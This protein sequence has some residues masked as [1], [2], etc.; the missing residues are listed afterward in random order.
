[1]VPEE[2]TGA[3]LASD[4]LEKN[5]AADTQWYDD[6]IPARGYRLRLQ[7][8]KAVYR[9]FQKLTDAEGTRILND[10]PKNEG[11]TDEELAARKNSIK[12]N[13]FRVTVS[14]IGS[15]GESTYGEFESIF[16]SDS[17]PNQVKAIYFTNI[18]AFRR[19]ANGTDPLNQFTVTLSFE[20]P[21]LF[22]PQTPVSHA[23]PNNSHVEIRAH[24]NGY[25]R[26]ARN[27]VDSKLKADRMWHA[28][29]HGKGI[30]DAGL[31]F[32]AL[33]LSLYFATIYMDYFFPPDGTYSSFRIP[34]YV[35]VVGLGLVLYRILT[36]YFKWAFP[37][38]VLEENRDSAT[39]HRV[40]LG[41]IVVGIIVSTVNSLVE[42][43]P[44][45]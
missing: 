1:M 3:T 7:S 38:N 33:P 15:D 5:A 17:I 8:I 9:E 41:A 40:L 30:Y 21:P 37:V 29:L 12:E 6:F 35:Y 43:L 4:A 25:F 39:K 2:A 19:N 11:E 42:R 22:D 10:M 16:D 31:W 34:F 28:P 14:I 27:I 44:W 26:A 32:V 18:T 20:K 23:T 45:F 13:A 36:G 24:D